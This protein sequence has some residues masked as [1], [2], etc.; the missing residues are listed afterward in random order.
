MSHP[1][2]FDLLISHAGVQGR[3]ALPGTLPGGQVIG[4]S[5]KNP[6]SPFCAPPQAAGEERKFGMTHVLPG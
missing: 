4:V 3:S 5:P 6:F 2:Y 1:E